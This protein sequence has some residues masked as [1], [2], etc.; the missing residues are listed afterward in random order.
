LVQI[1]KA[2]L[3]LFSG[4][5]TCGNEKECELLQLLFILENKPNNS[6]KLRG[7]GEVFHVFH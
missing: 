2:G 1:G 3:S 4:F 6:W 5:S 7:G